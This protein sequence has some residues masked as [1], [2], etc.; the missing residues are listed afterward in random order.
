MLSFLLTMHCACLGFTRRIVGV[1][2][3]ESDSI[4]AFLFNQIADNPDFHVRFRWEKDS[5]AIWD[6]RVRDSPY[7]S[8]LFDKLMAQLIDCDSFCNIRLLAAPQTCPT[9]DTAW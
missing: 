6:N 3:A 1:P 5:V 9:R 2:K 4:L 8:I 7:L